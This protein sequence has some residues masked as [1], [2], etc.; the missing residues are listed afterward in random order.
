MYLALTSVIWIIWEQNRQV[1]NRQNIRPKRQAIAWT[2]DA[3]REAYPNLQI[4]GIN[5]IEKLLSAPFFKAQHF[6]QISKNF[7]PSVFRI[8]EYGTGDEKLFTFTGISSIL[9]LS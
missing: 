1:E 7:Q 4:M 3:F 9:D 5:R 8:G 2:L 6:D